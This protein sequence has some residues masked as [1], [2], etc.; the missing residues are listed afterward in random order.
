MG[1]LLDTL[2]ALG[3]LLASPWLVYRALRTHRYREGWGEKLFGNVPRLARLREPTP[4]PQRSLGPVVWFHAVSVGEVQQLRTLVNAFVIRYPQARIVLSTT[5]SSGM[6]LM[7]SLFPGYDKFYLPLDFTWSVQRAIHRLGPR[8]IVLIELEVWPNLIAA[9][10]KA[11]AGVVIV[12]ARLSERSW[13]GYRRLGW[14]LR[15]V[16]GQL[17]WVAAQDRCYAERFLTMG[18]GAEKVSVVGNLKFDGAEFDRQHPEIEIRRRQLQL[19]EGDFV[20]VVGSTQAPEER[21]A[22]EAFL[23]LRERIR[24]LRMILVPRHPERFEEVARWLEEAGLPYHRRSQGLQPAVPNWQVLLGDTI[25]ELRWWWGLAD[26]A[27]V[28]GSFGDRGGQNMIEPAA[29]GV[30]T[31]V[32]PNTKNFADTMRL[33]REAKAITELDQPEKL[34]G[35]VLE[36]WEQ[37]EL[38]REVGS[39][40][41]AT[42]AEHR[43]ALGR[44][45]EGLAPWVV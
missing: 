27:F 30:A 20:W 5:T 22:I 2:Y 29:F 41:R 35:W 43:G 33:L 28:G 11:G 44:T 34:A 36:Y 1:Y 16:F 7:R 10:K 19:A 12:N 24:G 9:A 13:Q 45:L 26:L 32:G 40:A 37:E 6:T 42:I 38:R 8:L 3:L 14:F 17:D 18:V 23:R 25:G 39:R 21:Y 4:Q 15:P 31:A